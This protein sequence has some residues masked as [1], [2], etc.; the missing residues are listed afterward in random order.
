MAESSV[1][2][3]PVRIRMVRM[4]LFLWNPFKNLWFCVTLILECLCGKMKLFAPDCSVV[5][6]CVEAA[7]IEPMLGGREQ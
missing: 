2:E 6:T 1:P 3:Y 5:G 7:S 4:G